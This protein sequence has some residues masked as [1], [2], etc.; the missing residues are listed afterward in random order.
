[1]N[2]TGRWLRS[3]LSALLLAVLWPAQAIAHAELK[4]SLPRAGAHLGIAPRE[5]RLN[6]SEA[7]E[8]TFTTINLRGPAG[9]VVAL[10]PVQG[11]TDSRRSIVAAVQGQL[12]AGTYTV[13]WKV[14]GSDG[15]PVQGKFDFTIAPGA[16]GLHQLPPLPVQGASADSGVVG[17]RMSHDDATSL[18]MSAGFDAESPLY[19]AVRWL[20]YVGMLAGIG[21]FAFQRAVLPVLRRTER[22]ESGLQ[23]SVGKRAAFVGVLG[24]V[25][26]GA[27]VL[28]RLYAQS[29]AMHGATRVLDPGLVSSMLTTT[30]WGRGWL[31]QFVGVVVAL[32]GFRH[33]RRGQQRGWMLAGVGVLALAFSAALS[34][35]AAS[36][37]QLTALVI[38]ADG[39]HVI[40][41]G[42]WL[43]SLLVV[44]VV[45]IPAALRLDENV[46]HRAV[47][48]LINAF[49]PT[50]LVFAGL[51]AATGVF[52]AWIHLGQVSALWQTTYGK[53]LLV[54]LAVLSVMAGTGAYNWLR[55]KPA[56]G[57]AVGTAR[58]RK[59]ARF[60]IA[61]GVL[62]IV[63]T[64]IL[65]GTPTAMD[66][67]AMNSMKAAIE[68]PQTR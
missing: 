18:P 14:A 45:G 22:I 60:E 2:G 55:V 44:L 30:T 47:A 19:V 5:L 41:A 36:A 59:S 13:E 51:T 25:V 56:L 9:A 52:A 46:R 67:G 6:F 57:G 35:H 24:V 27:A 28:L 8:L 61:V 15:H 4:S 42:G 33:A 7:P 38:L 16:T 68:R 53:T 31:L 21:A 66:A 29:Y 65:V 32:A 17:S 58:I 10:G 49:S 23:A 12:S 37:P 26:V 62:V 54:K 39:F 34:G 1:M 20:L 3:V 63:V 48:D 40:G 50:A 43:G 11:A 64:A